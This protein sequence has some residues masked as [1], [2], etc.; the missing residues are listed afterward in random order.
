[1]NRLGVESLLL[2]ASLAEIRKTLGADSDAFLKSVGVRIGS[3][4][5]APA[6]D[7]LATVQAWMSEIWATLDLGN[8]ELIAE[9]RVLRIR[10]QLPPASLERR[11]WSDMVPDIVEGVY[12]NWM[13]RLDGR[14][15]LLRIATGDETLEFTYA[16]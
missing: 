14:G 6:S 10:H 1:M 15:R 11:Q 12:I 5:T 16:P 2:A 9:G 4:C 13:T 7:D 8:T 3:A